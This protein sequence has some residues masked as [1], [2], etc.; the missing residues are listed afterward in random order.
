MN[1]WTRMEEHRSI[2]KKLAWQ[3]SFDQYLQIVKK[4]P[5]CVPARPRKDI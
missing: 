2:E 3:G 4:K 5:G 1:F